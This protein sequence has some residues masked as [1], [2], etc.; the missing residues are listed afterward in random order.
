MDGVRGVGLESLTRVIPE[1][2]LI[3]QEGHDWLA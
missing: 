3:L 2:G 1:S